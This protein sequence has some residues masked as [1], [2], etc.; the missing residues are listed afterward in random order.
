ME[1]RKE[2]R[3]WMLPP[4]LLMIREEN[5]Q[6][7]E[8]GDQAVESIPHPSFSASTLSTLKPPAPPGQLQ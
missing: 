5:T 4:I 1:E 3:A 7:E 8:E 6:G 2:Q